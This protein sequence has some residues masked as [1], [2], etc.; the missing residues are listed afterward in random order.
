MMKEYISQIDG[1]VRDVELSIKE[2][3]MP[4]KGTA[5]DPELDVEVCEEIKRTI[6]ESI[7]RIEF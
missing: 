3:M 5:D 1:I 2:D 7:N 6:I 4:L